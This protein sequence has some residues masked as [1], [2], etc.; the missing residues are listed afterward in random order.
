MSLLWISFK[1]LY[2]CYGSTF[3]C[4]SK[5]IDT[6]F[7]FFTFGSYDIYCSRPCRFYHVFSISQSMASSLQ[8]YISSICSMHLK[9]NDEVGR[10]VHLIINHCTRYG[11]WSFYYYFWSLNFRAR[12]ITIHGKK[13]CLTHKHTHIQTH[14]LLLNIVFLVALRNHKIL[15]LKYSFLDTL[16]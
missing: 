6:V 11:V 16:F 12:L 3:K 15:K 7:F 1:P 5:M 4:Q 13:L 10:W 9:Q 14:T 8:L 2:Y